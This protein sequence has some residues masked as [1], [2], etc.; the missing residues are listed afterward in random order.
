MHVTHYEHARGALAIVELTGGEGRD[1]GRLARLRAAEKGYAHLALRRR[2]VSLR[3]ND[4]LGD[5]EVGRRHPLSMPHGHVDAQPLTHALECF[6]RRIHLVL[7]QPV[8]RAVVIYSNLVKC[9][10]VAL[11]KTPFQ[12]GDE[13]LK[14]RGTHV[15][16]FQLVLHVA[17]LD[18]A[19][20]GE[21]HGHRQRG[22]GRMEMIF[23]SRLLFSFAIEIGLIC[24]RGLRRSLEL[25]SGKKYP[26]SLGLTF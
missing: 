11:G 16:E 3:A 9:L 15:D 4:D 13:L 2:L 5:N 8:Q 19:G 17:H 20:H 25:H 6:E 14:A 10:A 1:E 22:A 18:F 23:P 7:R 21:L 12:L 26:A 24:N